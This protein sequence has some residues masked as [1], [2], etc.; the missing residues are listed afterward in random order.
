LILLEEKS[1]EVPVGLGAETHYQGDRRGLRN[2][3]EERI[4]PGGK[5]KEKD[6]FF[7]RVWVKGSWKKKR[8]I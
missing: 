2:G 8:G 5:S 6:S 3:G 1:K 4:F 7:E